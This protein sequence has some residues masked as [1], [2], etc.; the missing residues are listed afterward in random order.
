M[1]RAE[2]SDSAQLAL[3][4][5]PRMTPTWRLNAAKRSS[6][7]G[8]TGTTENL[9]DPVTLSVLA[10]AHY[11]FDRDTSLR[12][13]VLFAHG[14]HLSRGIDVEAVQPL[15]DFRVANADV[16]FGQDE[17]THGGSPGRGSTI[18]CRSERP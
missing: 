15:A 7:S 5:Q 12:A 4:L 14:E 16:R 10:T 9:I 6:L 3:I 11:R 2:R 13:A 18:R 8:S 17:N 1:A